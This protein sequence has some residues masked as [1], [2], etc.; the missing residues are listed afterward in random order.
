MMDFLPQDYPDFKEFGTP[1]CAESFPDAFFTEDPPPGNYV[2]SRKYAYENEAKAI[3]RACPYMARCLEY[4]LKNPE[5]VGIWG[6]TNER[7]R[8]AMRKKAK[9]SPINLPSRNRE[10]AVE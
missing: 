4:A 8:K 3:C 5:L 9:M 1:P 2:Y 10:T 6:G 7:Q